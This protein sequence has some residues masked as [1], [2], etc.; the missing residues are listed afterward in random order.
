MQVGGTKCNLD[1]VEPHRLLRQHQSFSRSDEPLC[2]VRHELMGMF[3]VHAN[4]WVYRPVNGPARPCVWD[5]RA[6]RPDREGISLRLL[7]RPLQVFFQYHS[8]AFFDRQAVVVDPALETA[9]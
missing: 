3:L 6:V 5:A 7:P 8:P 1:L 9:F 2:G 4:G